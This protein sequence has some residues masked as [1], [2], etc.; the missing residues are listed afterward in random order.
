M[1]G[2]NH[3]TATVLGQRAVSLAR[4]RGIMDY[5]RGRFGKTL[6]L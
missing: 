1:I 2:Y 3:L 4:I 5:Y 6:S